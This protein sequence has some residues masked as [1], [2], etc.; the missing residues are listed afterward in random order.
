M[1]K[2]GIAFKD[3]KPLLGLSG[4]KWIGFKNFERLLGDPGVLRVIRNTLEINLLKLLFCI[5]LPMF[6]AILIN[7][8]RMLTLKKMVQTVVYIPHFFTWVVVYSIFYIVFSTGGIVNYVISR[9]G[10]SQVMFFT[11]GFWFRFL[12]VLSDVWHMAGWGT[13]VY[14]A[15][16]MGIDSELY[17]AA[18][19]DGGN[20]LQQ[21][22][23]I[24]IPS[25]LPTMV[26]M[27][28][29]RLGRIMTDSFDQILAFYNPT[30]YESADIISTYVY[31]TGI[32]QANFSY[33]TAVGLFN[34]FAGLLMVLLANLLS[35]K[36]TGKSV[37]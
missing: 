4:S 33:A 31:R 36:F 9:L 16:I 2:I 7:E 37:W 18:V 1:T 34:S 32:G 8:M 12:L 22:W 15:A 14:L 24:T 29:I 25:L 27:V 13:I 26:L 17:D 35:R 20:R 6:F 19:V 28:S 21:I 23:Y 10:G 3:F 30:V 5:P 11:N